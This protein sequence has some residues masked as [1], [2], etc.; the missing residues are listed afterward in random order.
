MSSILI[1]GAGS[2]IGRATA[3]AFARAGWDVGLIGRR[4][5]ALEETAKQAGRGLVLAGD[6]TQPADV[7]RVFAEAVAKFGRLD[8]LFNNAGRGSRPRTLDE[9]PLEDWQA[10]LDVNLTGSVLCARAAFAQMRKQ[11]A[12]GGRIINNGS[13]SA[14]APRPGSTP[15]TVTKHAITGLTKCLSL[16]G[17]PFNIACGQI[18]IGNALTEITAGMVK[19]VPQADGRI[20]PEPTMDVEQVAKAVLMMAELP[21][22]AN[23]Q[24]MTVMATK[25]P[26]IGRG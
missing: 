6:V 10:V 1:T 26:F 23:V 7:D 5:D 4:A 14:H 9:T 22:S 12:Q 8:V 3:L 21:L 13:I 18:D 24:F 17:R 25:M 19:G 20:A 15:Y 2:G 11:D 16:D